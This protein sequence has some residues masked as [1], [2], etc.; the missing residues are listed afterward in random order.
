M[1]KVFFNDRTVLLTDDF[2]RNFQLKY[3]LFYKYRNVD[4]L[5]E[6][7]AFY[8]D[9][10]R[11][12]TLFIFHHDL[13]ELQERFKSCFRVVQAAGGLVKDESGRYLVIRRKGKWDLPKGK[14]N[15]GEPIPEAALREVT[16]E[17]GIRKIE[18]EA[19]L[20]TTW[21]CY[22]EHDEPILK[23]TSWFEMNGSG[24]EIPVP[25]SDEDITEAKWIPASQLP[26]IARNT[27]MAIIDLLTYKNLL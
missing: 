27:Y 10:K 21:H 7:I 1:Y 11:I 13:D 24:K 6:L 12:D 17:C 25:Q 9:L 8:R 20:M 3:G 23:R 26:E 19:P 14:V 2:L 5:R 18:I 4:D 15:P 22:W 16:E